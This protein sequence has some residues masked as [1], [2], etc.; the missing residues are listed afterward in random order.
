MI[1]KMRFDLFYDPAKGLLHHGG[2]VKDGKLNLTGGHYDMLITEARCAY[3]AAIMLD[4]IPKDAW[5]NLKSKLGNEIAHLNINR[6]LDLQSYT[7]TMFE[8]LTP[9]LLMKHEGT[10]LGEADHQAVRLQM[11]EM[12]AGIWGRS[13]ANSN[14]SKGYAAWGA[15]KLA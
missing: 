11:N 9:R 7:G 10:P 5:T 4:Q 3:A 2:S 15:R 12:T 14:T 8:Y 6:S 13:E 1:E